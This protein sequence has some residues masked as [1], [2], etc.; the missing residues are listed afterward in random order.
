MFIVDRL[1]KAQETGCIYI[2]F[3]D[4]ASR[5]VIFSE[6]EI[7]EA[8]GAGFR[9]HWFGAVENAVKKLPKIYKAVHKK[10]AKPNA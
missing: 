9:N 6:R 5:K 4:V 2:V 7:V 10:D 3:F 8:G 1:V